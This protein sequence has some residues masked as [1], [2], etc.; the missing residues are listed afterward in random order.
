MARKRY[1]KVPED[2]QA[3]NPATRKPLLDQTG[4]VAD[5]IKFGPSMIDLLLSNKS[6]IVT[7]E[8]INQANDIEA[9]I[10]APVD[11]YIEL[12]DKDWQELAKLADAPGMEGIHAR[13][14][15]P[16]LNAIADAQTAIGPASVKPVTPVSP[17]SARA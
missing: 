6:W 1:I 10:L 5:P 14:L 17:D 9:A 3:I 2:I 15:A 11:G 8:K 16:F 7:R 13:Q 4:N 12:D